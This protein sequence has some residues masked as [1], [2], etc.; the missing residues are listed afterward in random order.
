M[1]TS[2]A[3]NPHTLT[4]LTE[5]PLEAWQEINGKK[6]PVTVSFQKLSVYKA[7]FEI[8]QY[9]RELPLIIDPVLAWNTFIVTR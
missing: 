2:T 5:S 1:I 9:N 4:G 8:G 3:T 6:V 7:S